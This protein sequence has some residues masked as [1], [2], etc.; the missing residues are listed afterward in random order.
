MPKAFRKGSMLRSD[1]FTRFTPRGVGVKLCET[2]FLRVAYVGGP[3]VGVVHAEH[4][5]GS[6]PSILAASELMSTPFCFWGVDPCGVSHAETA[7]VGDVFS[8]SV[9]AVCMDAGKHLYFIELSHEAVGEVLEL[10]GVFFGPP[11]A[12]VTFLVE[13]AA[14]IV[15]TVGKLMAYHHPIPP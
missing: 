8:E 10:F 13:I 11:V 3:E 1:T 12:H 15:E 7:L 4:L 14:L 6:R 9:C 2:L 5:R